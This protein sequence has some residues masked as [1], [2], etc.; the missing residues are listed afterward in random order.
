M[1]HRI[2]TALGDNA[3]R[4]DQDFA[5]APLTAGCRSPCSTAE[6]DEVA[7]ILERDGAVVVDQLISREA[8]GAVEAELRPFIDA[9]PFGPDD[10]SGRRTKRTG[11]WSHAR[12]SVVN[13]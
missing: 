12:Q 5:P 7:A 2:R 1:R 10:F 13:W 9:T 6:D 3:E 4:G 11:A 8:M